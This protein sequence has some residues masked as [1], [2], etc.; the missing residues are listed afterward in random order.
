MWRYFIPCFIYDWVGTNDC[1]N[2]LTD[3]HGHVCKSNV[4]HVSYFILCVV[5]DALRNDFLYCVLY[6]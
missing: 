2:C 6:D 5:V 1:D 3:G 4:G